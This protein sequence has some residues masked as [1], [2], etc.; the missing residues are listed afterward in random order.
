MGLVPDGDVPWEGVHCFSMENDA[1]SAGIRHFTFSRCKEGEHLLQQLAQACL[2][3][4]G[5][6]SMRGISGMRS[7]PQHLRHFPTAEDLEPAKR[8]RW[9]KPSFGPGSQ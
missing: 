9:T 5:N 4:E 1:D 2:A 7:A 8:W 6:G 3:M